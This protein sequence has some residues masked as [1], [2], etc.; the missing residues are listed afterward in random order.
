[1][2][3]NEE[4]LIAN[5]NG[6]YS[7]STVSFANTRTY[8]GLLVKSDGDF[9]D[10][11][12]LLS[13]LFEE[14]TFSKRSY[15]L[16]TNYYE[17]TIF[18]EGF[19][20]IE[21]YSIVPYPFVTFNIDGNRIKKSVMVDVD[22]DTI[23]IRY[24]FLDK[25]PENISLYPLLAFRN[26]HKTIKKGDKKFT[27]DDLKDFYRF[28]DGNFSLF[29][30]KVGKFYKKDLWYYNFRYPVEEERGTN[31]NEDLYMPGSIVIDKMS[32]PLDITITAEN[33]SKIDY[34]SALGKFIK[35]GRNSEKDP[36][37][38]ALRRDSSNFLLY[39]NIIAGFHWFGPWGRDTFVSMPGLV[40]IPRNYELA[41]KIFE[42]YLIS[43]KGNLIPNNLNEHSYNYSADSS[44]WFIYALYKYYEY[45]SDN[46]FISSIYDKI[47]M[48]IQSYI[49]G[50]DDFSLEGKFIDVKTAPMT[51]MDGKNGETVFTPRTGKPID[52]NALWY[53]ALKSYV[54]FSNI[55]GKKVEQNVMDIL[56]DFKSEFVSRYFKDGTIA[57]TIDPVDTSFRPNF[58]FAYSLPFPLMDQ[59]L[60]IQKARR[61]LVTPYG[62][63]SLSPE[64]PAFRETYTGSPYERDR[65]YHNGTVWPWLAGP[66]ITA[67][68]RIGY[69][70]LEIYRYFAP[71]YTMAKVPE[72]FD[73]KNPE[74]PRG[75]IMQAWSYGELIRAYYEDILSSSK[76]NVSW[77]VSP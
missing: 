63:R 12:V 1:M 70:P 44:L 37:I 59:D 54:Y 10:R 67:A 40:L 5:K 11:Y 43:M 28:S 73:G 76:K 6:S 17:G 50:N 18:P 22:S 71:I 38:N 15:S 55:S 13:K 19:K 21:S 4:W 34:E 3:F 7:S 23:I 2:D 36:S 57:D 66:Y 39:D 35:R 30:S 64:N 77:T 29:I 9:Y 51:W 56:S 69:D 48:I 68:V 52:I 46:Y 14:V 61:E 33:G 24:E 16:D 20:F 8:H 75:C 53:N 65:S 42:K 32:N 26:F 58:L 25:M 74:K 72:I 41:R 45:S 31:S 62:L 27:A 47:K 60:L 49:E